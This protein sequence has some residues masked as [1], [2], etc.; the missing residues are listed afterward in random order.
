MK[1]NGNK[2]KMTVKEQIIKHIATACGLT[3][4][5]IGSKIAGCTLKTAIRIYNEVAN[6]EEVKGKA[7]YYL[8]K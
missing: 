1:D 2:N 3:N 5:V 4:P 6:R 7:Y 8:K